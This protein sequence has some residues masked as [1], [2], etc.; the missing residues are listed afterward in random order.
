MDQLNQNVSKGNGRLTPLVSTSLSMIPPA[1]PAL[2]LSERWIYKRIGDRLTRSPLP[3]HES[4]VAHLQ[5]RGPHMLLRPNSSNV[6]NRSTESSTNVY[7]ISNSA[8]DELMGKFRLVFR[9]GIV[10]LKGSRDQLW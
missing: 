2:H 8:T 7:F 3:W 5:R 9:G 4:R 1:K 6:R 10:V